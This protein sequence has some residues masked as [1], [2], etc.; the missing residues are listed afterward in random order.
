VLETTQAAAASDIPAAESLR[1]I[2]TR[3]GAVFLRT[4][5]D[6][7]PGILAWGG[8]Y[9]VLIALITL[10]YPVLQENDTLLGIARSI[11]LLGMGNSNINIQSMTSYAGY[12]A[13]EGLSLAPL[14]LSI[15]VI[16][17]ALNAISREEERGT[18]DILLST[19]LPRWRFLTEKAVAVAASLLGIL[20]IM[21]LTLV[22]STR[23]IEGVEISLLNAT[24][25]IWHIAPISLTVMMATLLISVITRTSRSAG[26]WAAL[27]VLASYFVRAITD[28]IT[29]VDWLLALRNLSIFSYYK[30][31]AALS[32]GFQWQLDVVLL[33]ASAVLFVL[34]LWRFQR[35][36]IGV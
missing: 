20:G 2:P 28:L 23:V 18:L 19:P 16:P 27:F 24:A 11:G 14:V 7:V 17:Q 22:V 9:G 33:S 12:I 13:F 5:R 8:G 15:Y 21:W 30:S 4:L 26:G 25:G 3:H 29:Q 6:N 31:I 35:R 1:P 36:D 32:Q 10:L 34:A